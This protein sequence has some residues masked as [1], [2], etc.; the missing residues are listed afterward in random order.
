MVSFRI[1]VEDIAE[2]SG[3][4]NAPS[5]PVRAAKRVLLRDRLEIVGKI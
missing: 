3:A 1:I 4:R 2:L 5:R